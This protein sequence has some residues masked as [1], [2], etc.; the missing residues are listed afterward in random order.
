MALRADG[1]VVGIDQVPSLTFNMGNNSADGSTPCSNPTTSGN[2][3]V[4][5]TN[6]SAA[7]PAT[8]DPFTGL[9][10]LRLLWQNNAGLGFFPCVANMSLMSSIDIAPQNVLPND[11]VGL[12][13]QVSFCLAN[14]TILPTTLVS[15]GAHFPHH[16]SLK[17]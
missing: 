13:L 1:L 10:R 12:S 8:P 3:P 4:L 5:L 14:V 15:D 7:M 11:K 16:L 9:Y 17:P 6:L 2:M